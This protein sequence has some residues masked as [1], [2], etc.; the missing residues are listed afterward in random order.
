ML[1][2]SRKIGEKI[3]IGES[4]E[5][6]ILDIKGRQASIGIKAPKGIA[7]YR[8]EVLRRIQEEN[9]E[10]ATQAPDTKDLEGLEI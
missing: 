4:I 8:E 6:V 1:I 3:K 5:V 2:I 10:A 7:I 9:I